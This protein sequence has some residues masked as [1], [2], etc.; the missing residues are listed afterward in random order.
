M[1]DCPR[2]TNHA[3]RQPGLW[4]SRVGVFCVSFP[5]LLFAPNQG[6]RSRAERRDNQG[7]TRDD[8]TFSDPTAPTAK[9]VNQTKQSHPALIHSP[10]YAA[11]TSL[12]TVNFEKVREISTKSTEL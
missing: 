12:L 4:I 3:K 11:R 1:F 9:T 10:L 7:V 5:F 2:A 8:S 6:G